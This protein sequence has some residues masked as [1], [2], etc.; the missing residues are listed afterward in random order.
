MLVLT[1]TAGQRIQIDQ[2]IVIT[3]LEVN[4]RHVRLGIEAPRDV[5]V[6]RDNARDKEDRHERK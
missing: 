5:P 3:V 1:R 6:R 2:D 4:G